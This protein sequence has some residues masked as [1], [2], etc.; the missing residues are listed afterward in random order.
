MKRLT[1]EQLA[2]RQMLRTESAVLQQVKRWTP[3]EFRRQLIEHYR[4]SL[5]TITGAY[6]A[7]RQPTHQGA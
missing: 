4:Q 6:R 7:Q 3:T 1:A 5:V 2:L